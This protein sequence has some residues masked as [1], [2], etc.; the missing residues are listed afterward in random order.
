MSPETPTACPSERAPFD[1]LRY[2]RRASETIAV[3]GAKVGSA[4]VI[5]VAIPRA[6]FDALAHKLDRLGDYRPDF[7][8]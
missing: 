2:S 7:I 4:E 6:R 5:K 8:H 1:P 3:G